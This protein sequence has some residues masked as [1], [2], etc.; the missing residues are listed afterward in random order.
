MLSE[1]EKYLI[2]VGFMA[3]MNH[4]A[5]AEAYL[6]EPGHVENL[7][8]NAPPSDR[9]I[10]QMYMASY[11]RAVELMPTKQQYR[12]LSLLRHLGQPTRTPTIAK[13]LKV[14]I[15][16][17]SIQLRRLAQSGYL[18]RYARPKAGGGREFHYEIAKH[19]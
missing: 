13:L 15:P 18:T 7:I 19:V 1:R 14:S 4:Y 11:N 16:H 2:H 8:D 12:I 3:A 5:T 17:A 9:T 10:R 6:A